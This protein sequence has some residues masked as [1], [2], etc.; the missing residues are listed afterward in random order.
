MSPKKIDKA[1]LPSS[2]QIKKPDFPVESGVSFSFKYFDS[3][4]Q[5]F[6]LLSMTESEYCAHLLMRLRDISSLTR[7]ELLAN[8]S[9]GL[10]F[11]PIV[12]S[13]TTDPA[14]FR[15]PNSELWA[16]A[17]QFS[18]SS[19]EYGRVHGFFRE[20]VFHIVWLDKEHALYAKK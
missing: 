11:H 5:K 4:H 16:D 20:H 14:G 12:W 10:R 2:G 13:E 17:H 15:I 3:T 6:P 1:K 9:A 8:R 19:N 18:I 7:K